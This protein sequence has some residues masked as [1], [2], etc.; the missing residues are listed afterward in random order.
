MDKLPEFLWGH[1]G[2]HKAESLQ[3]EPSVVISPDLRPHSLIL[4]S[5]TH[6]G[7]T[8]TRAAVCLC[9]QTKAGGG[10]GAGWF[11]SGMKG[12]RVRRKSCRVTTHPF[13]FFVRVQLV[14]HGLDHTSSAETHKHTQGTESPLETH[15]AAAGRRKNGREVTVTVSSYWST[16]DLKVQCAAYRDL[17]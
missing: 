1:G 7:V 9:Y 14:V 3:L 6:I 5:D 15:T 11:W 12:R 4:C 16:L 2:Q 10:G 13:L 8:L 17:Y